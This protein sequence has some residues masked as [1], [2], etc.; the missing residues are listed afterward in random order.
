MLPE[1]RHW[2]NLCEIGTS[3]RNVA[4]ASP[5]SAAGVNSAKQSMDKTLII[6]W[7]ASKLALA[8]LPPLNSRIRERILAAKPPHDDGRI[9]LGA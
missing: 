3:S 5:G 8:S 7:I 1:I 4:I 9:R 2:R 6:L